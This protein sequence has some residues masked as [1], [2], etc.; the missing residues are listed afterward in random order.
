MTQSVR[1]SYCYQSGIA[2]SQSV[3]ACVLMTDILNARCDRD[4]LMCVVK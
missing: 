3:R 1:K 4:T 2:P